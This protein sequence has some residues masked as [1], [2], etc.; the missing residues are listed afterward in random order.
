MHTFNLRVFVG[1][2]SEAEARDVAERLVATLEHEV[3]ATI[4][5]VRPYWKMKGHQ[6]VFLRLV[7]LVV[8]EEAYWKCLE[9]LGR[10]WNQQPNGREAIWNPGKESSF[11]EPSVVWAHLERMPEPSG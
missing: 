11:V 8:A 9:H 2:A 5:T 1:S 4:E 3:A 6:E 7:P 10:G